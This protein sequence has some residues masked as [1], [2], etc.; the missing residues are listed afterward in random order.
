M[1]LIVVFISLC[2]ILLPKW[3][4]A[5][6]DTS[7]WFAAP[8]VTVNNVPV[9]S[10]H[11]DRPIL[12]RITA[13]TAT[14][15]VTI[16]QPA[17]P[18]F[19]PITLFVSP[20]SSQT[21][22]LTSRIDI[23]ENKP[24]NT[25]LNYG[26]KISSDNFITA[27]YEVS[28]LDN[29]EM[30]VLKGR[31]ALGTNFFI[32]SQNIMSNWDFYTF[33]T[34][35]PTNSFDIVATENNTTI[36][37]TPAQNLVGRA[38]G[39]PFTI[40]LNRGE[41]F[42]CTGLGRLP[43]EHLMGS[44]VTS[45][46][47]IAITIK[48]DSIGGA[49]Y[50]GC[51]DL[52][53][54]QIVPTT[55]IGKKYITLPGFLNDP[56]GMPSDQVF[57]LA[58]QN[59]TTV[60]INGVLQATLNTG[61]T[62]RRQSFNEV[63]YI[64]TSSP[65]YALHLSGFGCE[66]GNAL[67]PQIECTGSSR[68]AFTRS[69]N[70]NL[71]MNI[72]V[73]AGYEGM[74]V[75]N[76][77]PSVITAG[78]FTN[79]PNTSGQWKY[80]RIPVSTA[81]LAMGQAAIVQ[82]SGIEFHLSIIEGDGRSGCRYG[83]FSDFNFFDVNITSNAIGGGLCANTSLQFNTTYNNALGIVFNWTGPNG[84]T[85]SSPNPIINNIG[86]NGTGT[87]TLNAT[88]PT[89]ANATKSLAI[90][91]YSIPTPNPTSNSPICT[92]QPLSLFASFPSATYNWTGPNAFN[93]TLQNPIRTNTVI[94]DTGIYSV[95][96][97]AN[98][99]SGTATTR[100]VMTKTPN[101]IITSTANRACRFSA[102][103]LSNPAVNPTADT[104]YSWIGPNGFTSNTPTIT[105]PS[106]N[107]SDTGMYVLTA[108]HLGCSAKDSSRITISPSPVI[109]FP[110]VPSVCNSDLPFLLTASETSGLAG[111][112][113]FSGVGVNNIGLFTPSLVT[114]SSTN[115]L[116]TYSAANGCVSSA[117]R[118]INMFP[119]PVI[120]IP[121]RKI[122]VKAGNSVILNAS[123]SGGSNNTYAWTPGLYL[124]NPS[125]LTPTSLPLSSLTYTLTAVSDSGCIATDSIRVELASNIIIPNV[126]SPNGDGINDF[127]EIE[128]KAGLLY[129]RA[130]VFDRYG[131]LVH[132]SF[133]SK[134][135]WN[136]NYNGKPLPVA[137][138]YYVVQV[139]DGQTSQN[140]G[141]WVQILR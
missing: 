81:I 9:Q 48:D 51:L 40:T 103:Q 33:P 73:P 64:E 116:Y 82:N 27:Y 11:T 29:P 25:V 132:T 34:P 99:C 98:G 58:T 44:T 77:N 108:S 52:A 46:K 28:S 127:W 39:V 7:F 53:G 114:G 96:A 19:V 47:P 66:V 36:T 24:A 37:I 128:D 134:I 111:V 20:N 119:T 4:S 137:T 43:N 41:T 65:V 139:S 123:I 42:S 89:C 121:Q 2:F 49:G 14:A 85:S 138:Y 63:L 5:Q 55:L 112:G 30:F 124:D 101:S 97:T 54:D 12:L 76:G 125:I 79:V 92:G 8:E 107:F 45:N 72:L 133:G 109:V 118:T 136:G 67:L 122:G 60:T 93:S 100:V 120:T 15:N 110:P 6:A 18:S 26:L 57:I 71:F 59:N 94:A 80:A 70:T 35:A 117:S 105:L 126:F 23:I 32:P 86:V 17:N 50:S 106:V 104:T 56:V 16:S 95:T 129:L 61:E 113:N 38:A 115:I 141:G 102:V 22:D 1:Q 91:V 90:T 84:F 88:K 83:Y 69:V 131:K 68:V 3:G 13:F 135:A 140:L 31:N 130:N 62:F 78:A 74:F 10:T 75:F 21:V 87:Y